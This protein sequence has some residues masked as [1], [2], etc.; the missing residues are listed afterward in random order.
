M[1]KNLQHLIKEKR[2]LGILLIYLTL[3]FTLKAQVKL[4]DGSP[5]PHIQALL[6]L[7][8]S[9]KGLLLPRVSTATRSSTLANAP[10]GLV[11]YDT[12]LNRLMIK[13][14]PDAASWAALSMSATLPDTLKG[15]VGIY[16]SGLVGNN[17]SPVLR[18]TNGS[19][20][21]QGNRLADFTRPIA[22]A[23]GKSVLLLGKDSTSKNG[24]WIRYTH[25]GDHNNNNALSFGFTD[26]E[27]IVSINGN[28]NVRF[29][30]T[31]F[32][33]PGHA[34]ENNRY[35]TT[36]FYHWNKA[37]I[38]GTGAE[39]AQ[40]LRIGQYQGSN[41]SSDKYADILMSLYTPTTDQSTWV[42]KVEH[43]LS[44]KAWF[45]R[46]DSN[47]NLI[48]G[49]G[50][51]DLRSM[52]LYATGALNKGLVSMGHRNP[53]ASAVL[54]L[55]YQGPSNDLGKGLLLPRYSTATLNNANFYQPAAG[56]LAYDQT[57]NRVVMNAGTPAS[58][59]WQPM[60]LGNAGSVTLTGLSTNVSNPNVKASSV[61]ILTAQDGGT[62]SFSV[63][64]K[65]AGSFTI[66]TSADGSSKT[67][68]YLIIN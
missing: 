64:N 56:L 29:T 21:I 53:D 9:D 35:S 38:V 14:G 15:L 48:L 57:L 50:D 28:G 10:A 43:S 55:N 40:T 63:S 36:S 22:T 67:V 20:G 42:H 41:K 12:D 54:D 60:V 34:D 24:A 66:N 1:R 58:R 23:G 16:N 4:G 47:Q 18:V 51:Q 39:Y 32:N 62:A 11:V 31:Q 68:G 6:D 7:E 52:Y 65:A 8:A 19:T 59:D 49:K 33:Q 46:F 25:A 2:I 61:I 26:R 5:T 13:Q 3:G 27:D 44:G 37:D 45:L 30:N 17:R